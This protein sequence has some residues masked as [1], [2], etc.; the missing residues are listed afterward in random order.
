MAVYIVQE[1]HLINE[2]AEKITRDYTS[3]V[4]LVI[5]VGFFL[6]EF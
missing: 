5:S 3:Y 1:D 4:L 2:S 6:F